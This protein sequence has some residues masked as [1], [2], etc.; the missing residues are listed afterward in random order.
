[1]KYLI[2]CLLLVSC[3]NEYAS[4]FEKQEKQEKKVVE[5]KSEDGWYELYQNDIL[6]AT[7]PIKETKY[8]ECGVV[9][10]KCDNVFEYACMQN[11]KYKKVIK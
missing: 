7:C 10:E 1:M 2:L 5:E 4:E 3:S 8:S 11:I 6:L 9:A